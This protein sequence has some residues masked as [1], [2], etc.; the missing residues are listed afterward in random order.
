MLKEPTNHV[1]IPIIALTYIVTLGSTKRT[2]SITQPGNSITNSDMT[3]AVQK[4]NRVVTACSSAFFCPRNSPQPGGSVRASIL[5]STT[6]LES[7]HNWLATNQVFQCRRWIW[8]VECL[9]MLW[10]FLSLWEFVTVFLL[11]LLHQRHAR[12]LTHFSI[13][14]NQLLS[15]CGSLI[16]TVTTSRVNYDHHCLT[17]SCRTRACNSV[18]L[19]SKLTV[20][21]GHNNRGD[22]MTALGLLRCLIM[23]SRWWSI[24]FVDEEAPQMTC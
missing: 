18:N 10:P 5:S 19:R 14:P 4:R 3:A 2:W 12:Q 21:M 22:H 1:M 11:L 23:Q 6:T 15:Y 8:F 9:K 20:I 7:V 13:K 16:R 24:G 17:F